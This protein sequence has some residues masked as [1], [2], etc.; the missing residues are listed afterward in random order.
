MP[1]T[2]A[3]LHTAHSNVP[4]FEAAAQA[5]PGGALRLTHHVHPALLRE[6]TPDTLREA[7]TLL[8]DLAQV[9]DAV[10]LTCSTIGAAAALAQD[11]ARPV[12]RADGAL[13]EAATRTGGRVQVLYAA[14][15][16]RAPTQAVFEAAAARTGATL[17]LHL[18][19]GAWAM[20]L[21]GDLAAYHARIAE[22]ARGL[23]G[24]IVLAQASMAGAAALMPE[25]PPL[26][27]P[28]IGVM[29]AAR[30]AL[31]ARDSR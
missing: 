8:H 28:A 12:L 26:T 4:L 7:A 1:L 11:A 22:T 18:V 5:L 17:H 25:A 13:A 21:A 9:A 27:V 14:P 19:E 24:R 3:C 30:A 31:T 10:L 2:I 23:P 15:T 16:T 20:F 29:A 6:P